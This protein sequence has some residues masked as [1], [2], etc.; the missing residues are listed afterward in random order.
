MSFAGI[1]GR[2]VVGQ[3]NV[4]FNETISLSFTVQIR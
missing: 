4:L 3:N 1:T 2:E